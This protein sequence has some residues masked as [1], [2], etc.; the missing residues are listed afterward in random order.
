MF[1]SNTR[2]DLTNRAHNPMTPSA[3]VPKAIEMGLMPVLSGLCA[4][5]V[6]C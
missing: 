4:K 3:S 6:S 5:W 1:F 2:G